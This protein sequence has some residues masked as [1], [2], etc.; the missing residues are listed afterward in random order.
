MKKY[1]NSCT[2]YG[3]SVAGRIA[4][5]QKLGVASGIMHI[6]KHEMLNRHLNPLDWETANEYEGFKYVDNHITVV[7]PTDKED[8]IKHNCPIF[9]YMNSWGI[10]DMLCL[11]G[12]LQFHFMKYDK[13]T[14]DFVN[15][16]WHTIRENMNLQDTCTLFEYV[17]DRLKDLI[18]LP[19][20]EGDK[21]NST[22]AVGVQK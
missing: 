19:K 9:T 13:E 17:E 6:I 14:K 1:H 18:I 7:I 22:G 8:W 15:G 20:E 12:E 2:C 3:Q 11:G 10:I 21:Y 4:Y 16:Y 5:H